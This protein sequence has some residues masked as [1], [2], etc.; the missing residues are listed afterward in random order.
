MSHAPKQVIAAFDFDKTLTDCDSFRHFLREAVG[1]V[2]FYRGIFRLSPVFLAYAA[3]L[4]NNERT[5]ALVVKNFFTGWPERDLRER[6]ERFAEKTLPSLLVPR[7]MRRLGW[8]QK[9]NHRVILVSASPELYLQ[10]WARRNGIEEVLAT[11]LEVE[12]GKIKGCLAGRNCY[13]PEKVERL[14]GL[15][16]NPA[17]YT[18]YAYGDSR[19][20]AELLALADHPFFRQFPQE[21]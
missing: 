6:A 17:D 11:R 4:V 20:D 3:G 10:P 18:I 12:D 9:Q 14:K 13:G 7:A 16:G 8:H 2:R 1:P 21:D 15:I 5:K 19:G